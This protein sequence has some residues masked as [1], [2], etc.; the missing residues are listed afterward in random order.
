LEE[1]PPLESIPDGPVKK[2][3]ALLLD[4]DIVR[5]VVGT[6][7]N[8]A[9]QDPSLPRELEIRRN[10]MKRFCQVLESKYMK[11]TQIEFL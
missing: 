4:S 9:H 10:L 3:T 1:D 7:I 11:E 8:E 6:R 2:L 5:I